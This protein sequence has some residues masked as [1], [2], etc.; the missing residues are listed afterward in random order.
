VVPFATGEATEADIEERRREAVRREGEGR[1]EEETWRKE[2]RT[3]TQ[4]CSI[5]A[6]RRAGEEE[7]EEEEEEEARGERTSSARDRT[8]ESSERRAQER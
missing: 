3:G 4:P 6:R 1:G 7:E 5:M 2:K 8:V